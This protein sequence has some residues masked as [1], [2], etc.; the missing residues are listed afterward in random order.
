MVQWEGNVQVGGAPGQTGGS[1]MGGT[2]PSGVGTTPSPSTGTVSTYTDAQGNVHVVED[3]TSQGGGRYDTVVSGFKGGYAG[4]GFQRQAATVMSEPSIQAGILTEARASEKKALELEKAGIIEIRKPEPE[5]TVTGQLTEAGLRARE[6]IQRSEEGQREIRTMQLRAEE[7]RRE[8]PQEQVEPKPVFR[9]DEKYGLMVREDI[10]KQRQVEYEQQLLKESAPQ[11]IVVSDVAIKSR[12]A[13]EKVASWIRGFG[14]GS[15]KDLPS[16]IRRP[17]EF[18]GT[19]VRESSAKIAEFVGMVEP[20]GEVIGQTLFKVDKYGVPDFDYEGMKKFPS[21]VVLGGLTFVGGAAKQIQEDPAQFVSDIYIGKKVFELGGKVATKTSGKVSEITSDLITQQKLKSLMKPEEA[22]VSVNLQSAY[23]KRIRDIEEWK[24][25][26]QWL[27]AERQDVIERLY[28]ES[29]PRP[30]DVIKDIKYEDIVKTEIDLIPKEWYGKHT[31]FEISPEFTRFESG[32]ERIAIRL[33]SEIKSPS[34]LRI[35]QYAKTSELKEAF[36]DV[37]KSEIYPYG[38]YTELVYPSKEY[39]NILKSQQRIEQYAKTSELKEAFPDVY[40][41]EAEIYPYGRY[42][43]LVDK[44]YTEGEQFIET[45]LKANLPEGM[46]YPS[47]EYPVKERAIIKAYPKI[48]ITISERTLRKAYE[49]AGYKYVKNLFPLLKHIDI[50]KSSK[51]QFYEMVE[52]LIGRQRPLKTSKIKGVQ[53]AYEIAGMTYPEKLFYEK[54]VKTVEEIQFMK[55]FEKYTQKEITPEWEIY[56]YGRYT[57]LVDRLYTEGEQFVETPTKAKLP[58]GMEYPTE[59]RTIKIQKDLDK[60]KKEF[61]ERQ[62]QYE[63]EKGTD[64]EIKQ[65]QET[66]LVT[67]AIQ[68]EIEHS[69]KEIIVEPQL[70]DEPTPKSRKKLKR[71]IAKDIFKEEFNEKRA[72]AIIAGE[73]GYLSEKRTAEIENQI[74]QIYELSSE[75]VEVKKQDELVNYI[76]LLRTEDIQKHIQTYGQSVV[77]E[78]IHP[79]PLKMITESIFGDT[80]IQEPTQKQ[81]QIYKEIPFTAPDVEL[82]PPLPP[83]KPS[84][85]KKEEFKQPRKYALRTLYKRRMHPVDVNVIFQP[86]L[87]KKQKPRINA[88]QYINMMFR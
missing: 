29:E 11:D 84:K 3:Y 52:P 67:K 9:Y 75:R 55:E 4:S 25:Y 22:D 72:L 34:R 82:K 63:L 57:E 81:I 54:K 79:Q 39:L 53:K 61:K 42:M 7:F 71:E 32:G 80:Y 30:A 66:V 20:T 47:F 51:E 1:G 65:G 5:K 68:K 37:Y 49:I 85:P 15:T 6:A 21:M 43:E 41:S 45:P 23:F 64:I 13:G 59:E 69:A 28:P 19:R 86:V 77:Q 70:E 8:H 12:E 38:K 27:K 10:A 87:L 14:S 74:T 58:E 17:L 60:W 83:K 48:K 46:E 35:E 2:T 76:M 40:K 78:Q 33:T 73:M 88:Q 18:A 31:P 36:P 44:L 16:E 26:E 56:P 62:E 24:T 50:T